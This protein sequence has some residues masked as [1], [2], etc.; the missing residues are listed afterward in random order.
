MEYLNAI[1]GLWND[2]TRI[3]TPPPKISYSEWLDQYYFIP[4]GDPSAGKWH[5]LP[6]QREIA[7]CMTDPEVEKITWMKSARVGYTR[8][9]TGLPG[10]Y[11]HQDPRN[12]MIVQPTI[13]DAQ[14]YSKDEIA[15]LFR[16]IPVLEQLLPE[17]KTRDS[18][19]TIL[20][21]ELPGMTLFL[22]GANSARGFRRISAGTVIFDEVDGYPPS[23]GAE[24]DQI[25]L[26]YRRAEY[27]WNRKYI[28]GSTP[29]E[30]GISRIEELYE[31]SDKRLYNV[32]CPFCG[33]PQ[34]LEW[35][36][37]DFSDLGTVE[38]PV[39]LCRSCPKP[40]T[41]G[42]HRWMMENGKWEAEKDF[43][44]HA[45]FHL[46]A[47]Y[48]YSPNATWK[49]IVREFKAALGNPLK[50]KGFVNT[51]RGQTWEEEGEEIDGMKLMTRQ[52]DFEAIMPA[53]SAILTAT[54]DVQ[55][56]RLEILLKA[57]GRD[58]ESWTLDRIVMVGNPAQNEIWDTLDTFLAI[59]Y[60]HM[61]GS[62]VNIHCTLI[63]SGG[64]H[65]DQVY[66]FVKDKKSRNI[67]AIKG[68]KQH[69]APILS[70]PKKSTRR[71]KAY[72]HNV[73]LITIGVNVA[74]DLVAS[75]LQ[76]S[77]YGPGY[78]HF[79]RK[80]P[81]EYFEQL[82][83]EKRRL[84]Y[85]RGR[86]YYLWEIKRKGLSNE[87]W[88]LEVYSVPAVRLVCPDVSILNQYVETMEKHGTVSRPVARRRRVISKGV[89]LD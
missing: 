73:D 78:I 9:V 6:Y 83:A 77:T 1:E 36:N 31:E 47:A 85:T 29:T 40:I 28:H 45:G 53:E 7:D 30:R 54:V 58:E 59:P 56:D 22:I 89:K 10:Y 4:P 18:K 35:S 84:K 70:R 79:G 88:D 32:P 42:H 48:S 68:G 39:Y 11:A 82:T 55:K 49:H 17:T 21:K 24:G 57:W 51:W 38:D 64:H 27:Y 8:L 19:N 3:W 71:S 75:R 81:S 33:H 72:K 44:G 34:P 26:G 62:Q 86:P 61:L 76:L 46:W 74:K 60:P 67:F 12:V 5:T 25:T 50:M 13:E 41:Y 52:E 87:A 15:S 23:A 43:Y 16:D 14:G 37:F 80:L 65:T 2:V 66:N 63:D 20:R 69:D